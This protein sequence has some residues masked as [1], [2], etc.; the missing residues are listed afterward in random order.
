MPPRS[1]KVTPRMSITVLAGSICSSIAE[2]RDVVDT[3]SSPATDSTSARG[4]ARS[5]QE[6][7][8]DGTEPAVRS[9]LTTA[10]LTSAIT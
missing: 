7:C 5:A 1:M 10:F 3:S 9:S 4:V 6:W 2:I 8:A